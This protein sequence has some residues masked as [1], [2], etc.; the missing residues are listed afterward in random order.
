MNI[1]IFGANSDIAKAFVQN[2]SL[3]Y[4]KI[5]TITRSKIKHKNKNIKNISN[6]DFSKKINFEIL[7]GKINSILNKKKIDAIFYFPTIH[8]NEINLKDNQQIYKLFNVNTI[9]FISFINF[10]LKKKIENIHLGI[11][12]SVTVLKNTKSN[13]HYGSSKVAL[14]FYFKGLSLI[15]KSLNVAIYRIGYIKTKKNIRKK[16]ILP[17]SNLHSVSKYLISGINKHNG[18]KY[19]P[20]WWILIKIV[21]FFIPSF[22][23]NRFFNL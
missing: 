4:D 3:R 6:I 12:S 14:E 11:I 21:L 20:K 23:L 9:F 10:I 5:I 2:N 1:V 18:I 19:F 16:T 17:K 15:K 13:I 8:E 7:L 22:L